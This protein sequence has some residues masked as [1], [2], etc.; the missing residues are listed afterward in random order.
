MEVPED[1]WLSGYPLPTWMY[2]S[3]R[4]Q[5]GLVDGGKQAIKSLSQ[6]YRL[7]STSTACIMQEIEGRVPSVEVK[8]L[9]EPAWSTP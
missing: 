8:T 2:E 4:N 5:P 1:F 9:A 3:A 6:V 7:T